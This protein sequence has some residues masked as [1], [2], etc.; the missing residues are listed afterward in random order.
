MKIQ[1]FFVQVSI[2]TKSIL[3]LKITAKVSR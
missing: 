2:S 3:L 1:E